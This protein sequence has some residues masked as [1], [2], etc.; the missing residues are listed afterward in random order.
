M[1]YDP[2]RKKYVHLTPEEWVRQNFIRYLI[3]EKGFPKSR[4]SI[5]K[6]TQNRIK[7]ARS[8]L[9][10]HGRDGK[11]LLLAECKA[12]AIPI[13]PKTVEQVVRYNVNVNAS[14]L[15]VTNGESTVCWK[16]NPENQSYETLHVIPSYGELQR[17]DK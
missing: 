11:P 15:V 2:I 4:F 6:S 16:I 17:D 12:A 13:T 9:I 1:I 8:D 7:T 3:D 5:E 10:I 14:Y